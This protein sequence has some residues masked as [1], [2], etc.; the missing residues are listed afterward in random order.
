MHYGRRVACDGGEVQT[1][2]C[3]ECK[4]TAA[5]RGAGWIA[6]RVDTGDG[7]DAREFIVYCPD[8][9][10]RELGDR[11]RSARPIH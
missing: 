4:R 3:E 7:A 9:A 8:C 6:F 2:Q 10:R 5:A 11:A 1:L